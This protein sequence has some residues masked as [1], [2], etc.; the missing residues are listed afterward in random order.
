MSSSSTRSGTMCRSAMRCVSVLGRLEAQR[1]A[2][3]QP[4][5]ASSLTGLL[6]QLEVSKHWIGL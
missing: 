4:G 1:A 5:P 3:Q 2:E 6:A